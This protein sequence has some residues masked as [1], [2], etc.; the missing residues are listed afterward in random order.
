MVFTAD[1]AACPAHGFHVLTAQQI[2]QGNP[3][4]F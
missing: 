3:D 2:V 4:F 1:G